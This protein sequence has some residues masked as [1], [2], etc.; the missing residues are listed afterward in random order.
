MHSDAA[1]LYLFLQVDTQ[2][3]CN[4]HCPNSHILPTNTS[5]LAD[6]SLPTDHFRGLL[7]HFLTVARV[8][9]WPGQSETAC[10]ENRE[11]KNCVQRC[12]IAGK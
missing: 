9:Q 6:L 10:K 8:K 5:A 1:D 11:Q 7:Q 4:Q 12:E 3:W 2:P